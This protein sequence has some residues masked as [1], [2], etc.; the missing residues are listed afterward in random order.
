MTNV[1]GTRIKGNLAY[2][3]HGAHRKRLIDA[4][5]PDVVKVDL[6]FVGNVHHNSGEMDLNWTVT[7]VEGGAGESTIAV[8]DG[9]GGI[10][11][12]TTDAAEND[13]INAQLI[14]EAFE[15][16]GDQVLYFGAFGCTINDVTQSDFFLGLAITDTDILGGVT[17]RI[18]FQSIDGETSLKCMLEK[19]STETLSAALATLV[20]ATAF[21][22]E[23]FW[24]GRDSTLEFFVNGVSA[25]TLALTN[26][27]ND[28]ALR[29]TWQFL[30]GETAAQTMDVDRIRVI[31]I[32]R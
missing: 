8:V 32:G 10:A 19:D 2:F 1:A 27:P 15:L 26:L 3:D 14:G 18:G 13:G 23:F 24:D 25:G 31:Q 21:D 22:L 12:I 20:D 16:T 9:V 17:D 11:R 30:T 29:L 7:R 5:G 4:I 28:E 6:D